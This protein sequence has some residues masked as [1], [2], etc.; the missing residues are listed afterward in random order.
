MESRSRLNEL[1]DL[2]E[3][4]SKSVEGAASFLLAAY[5]KMQ[6]R[7]SHCGSV[8]T[9]LTG[10]HEVADLIPGLLSGFRI[11]RCCEL[12]PNHRR[13]LDPTLL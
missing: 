5:N 8:V 1:G 13:G 12:R 11:R 6:R 7:S 9:N 4:I 10:I 3:E 2:A